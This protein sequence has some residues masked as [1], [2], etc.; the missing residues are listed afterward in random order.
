MTRPASDRYDPP[1]AVQAQTSLSVRLAR[2]SRDLRAAQ[3]LRY[4]VFIEEMGGAGPLVD[5]AER[6]ER[7]A[8]DPVFDH[9]LLIDNARD[10]DAGEHV[11]GVYRLLPDSRLSEAGQF[12]CDDEFDLAPLRRSGRRLLELGRSCIDSAH[13]GGVGMLQMWQGLAEY[14]R[15][16]EIEILFGAASFR[17]T[18]P[19]LWA[20]P[21]SWLHQ[22]HLAPKE[23]RVRPRVPCADHLLP[24]EALDRRQA[25]MQ[26]PSLIKAYLRLGGVVG[27]GVYV[28][29]AFH[30]TDVC[31]IL[32]TARM[33][34]QARAFAAR[35]AGG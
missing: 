8:F 28:D 6:L 7:D 11:V 32:D 23:L 14:V 26:M 20:Q 30:T 1:A 9:L 29:P 10:P 31:I 12:Y 25:L 22:H 35:G 15:A 5:H 17:G 18:D 3:H 19:A 2:D 21:L 13:R 33:S 16:R 4:R 34:A 27:E 24:P